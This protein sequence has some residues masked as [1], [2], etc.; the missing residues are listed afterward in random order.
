MLR[1]HTLNRGADEVLKVVALVQREGEISVATS[2]V[3]SFID[4]KY[5][6]AVDRVELRAIADWVAHTDPSFT[7][8][9]YA[10]VFEDQRRAAAIPL[11]ELLSPKATNL[12]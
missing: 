10:H 3:A 5:Q 11:L 4:P 2:E 9:R 1:V 12:N 7:I 8:K 6:R